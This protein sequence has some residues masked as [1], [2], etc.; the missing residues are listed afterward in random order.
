MTTATISTRDKEFKPEKVTE[1]LKF[2][3]KAS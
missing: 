2:F 1:L 3:Y